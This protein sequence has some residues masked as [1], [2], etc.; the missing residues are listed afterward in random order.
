VNW[1]RRRFRLLLLAAL[2][3][4]AALALDW[5]F[6]LPLPSLTDDLSTVVVD[7]EGRP[8]RAFPAPS[9]V[10]RFAV[11]EE[12]VA[13]DYFRALFAY[14][15]RH[16]FRHVGVNPA[17]VVR[18]AGQALWHGE[19]VSGASTL[20]MQ[21][22]RLIEPQP[23]TLAGK[24]RQ[25]FRALQLEKQLSK[26]EILT[27]YLNYAP[28]GGT[29]QGVAAASFA[30]LGKP[31]K[32]LSLAEAALLVALPQAPSRLRPDRHP[33][34][35]RAAR[36]KVLRRM[37]QHGVIDA[38]A[39][40]QAMHEPVESRRLE[41]PMWA[42]HLAQRLRT[43]HPGAAV[44]RSSIDLE[45]QMALQAR[46][47]EYFD[48][49]D[50]RASGALVVMDHRDGSVLAY[51]GGVAFGDP[52]RAGHLDLVRAWR[53]PGSTLKPFIY[54]L[55]LDEGLIHSQSLLLDVPLDFADYRPQNVDMQFRG[56]VAAGEALKRSLNLP[57][58][59]LLDQISP[60]RLAARLEHVGLRLNISIGGEPNLSLALGGGATTLE[61][62]I[63]AHSALAR[64]GASLRPQLLQGQTGDE[65]RLLSAGAAWI[66]RDMLRERAQPHLSWKTGTSYGFR[67]SWAIGSTPDYTAGVWIGRPDGTPMPGS[68]GADTALP[69]LRQVLLSLPRRSPHEQP[70]STVTEVDICWPLGRAASD[71]AATH[72]QRKLRAFALDGRVPPT[73]PAPGEAAGWMPLVEV[74]V[75]PTTGERLPLGCAP[76][77]GEPLTIA[78]WPRELEPWLAPL[79][80]Q[81]QQLPT[82][83]ATCA[84]DGLDALDP[85]SIEGLPDGA[86]LRR[87]P[88][89][90][91]APRAALRAR[92]TQGPVRWLVNGEYRALL[93]PQQPFVHVF[94]QRGATDVL[95]IAEHGRYARLRL[96]VH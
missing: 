15:D 60:R 14:E 84:P 10:W 79:L 6:P 94:E 24:L 80:T 37:V 33:T 74:R 68:M 90:A 5:L 69:L 77:A 57:A 21:V 3:V 49:L 76:G 34:A 38:A 73:L 75:D 81:R 82:R 35:A 42:P 85:L 62:L 7:R 18:A 12:E 53:S 91:G 1:L 50:P 22:A 2:A 47:T 87:L 66:V 31:P 95:A 45:L 65:R 20:T 41:V 83:R 28:Y 78:R 92:G 70:P 25:M 9:G 40:E 44:I 29:V 88:G 51:L 19:V 52:G 23:R 30:Y 64:A 43:A 59:Q 13:P 72:C 26:R 17:A 63:G 11:T 4:L 54:G 32:S 56:P 16:F 8:L 46:M 39:A 36:D 48:R 61:S 96:I 27:L 71:T 86:N 89:A 55:A 58:V 93:P 67:D